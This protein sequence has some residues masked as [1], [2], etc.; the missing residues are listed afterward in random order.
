MAQKNG[1]EHDY[2]YELM[3]SK[4]NVGYI[5]C[6]K[7]TTTGKLVLITLMP[8]AVTKTHVYQLWR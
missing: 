8:Q 5:K 3:N 2:V 1:Q 6:I 4:V 7:L